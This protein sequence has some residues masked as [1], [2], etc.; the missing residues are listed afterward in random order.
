MAGIEIPVVP[1]R[2]QVAMTQPFAGLPGTM[3]M[4]IFLEDGFHLRVRDLA[5]CSS[6]PSAD[7]PSADPF[8]TSFE[9]LAAGVVARAHHRVPCLR[10]AEIDLPGPPGGALRDVAR[11]PR[12]RGTGAPQPL[13]DERLVR[14]RG[15][16]LPRPGTDRRRR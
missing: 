6:S 16:A 2:R 5:A 13:P 10:E 14:P 3:P 4:T 11:L 8:D 12:S 1:A 7:L 15:H 9:L